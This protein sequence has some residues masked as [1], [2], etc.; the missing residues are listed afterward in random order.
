MYAS[1]NCRILRLVFF[2]FHNVHQRLRIYTTLFSAEEQTI[3]IRV[4]DLNDHPTVFPATSYDFEMAEAQPIGA[5]VAILTATDEDIGENAQHTYTVSGT[6]AAHFYM[7][8]IFV[9]QAGVVKIN[10]VGVQRI[11]CRYRPI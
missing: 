4:G 6:D 2:K 1:F 9:A 7:D 11:S 10:Q 3:W 5:S 8:S